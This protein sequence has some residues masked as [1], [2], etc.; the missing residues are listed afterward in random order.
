M[1]TLSWDAQDYVTHSLA[2]KKWATELT[3]AILDIDSPG[4]ARGNLYRRTLSVENFWLKEA[5]YGTN[6]ILETNTSMERSRIHSLLNMQ[7]C[8]VIL[9]FL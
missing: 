7:V 6:G 9:F 3:E 8:F 1:A 5:T 2:Q 4:H